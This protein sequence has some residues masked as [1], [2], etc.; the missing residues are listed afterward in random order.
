MTPS[1]NVNSQVNER[2]REERNVT[3]YSNILIHHHNHLTSPPLCISDSLLSGK[4]AEKDIE[5]HFAKCI[6]ALAERKAVLLGEAAL[7]VT[8]QS[9]IHSSYTLLSGSLYPFNHSLSS[10]SSH[11]HIVKVI[12]DT[13]VKLEVSIKACRKTL[14]AGSVTYAVSPSTAEIIWKVISSSLILAFL[15]RSPLLC[16]P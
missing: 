5:E 6:N 12:E 16:S 1:S 10:I 13:R 7:K 4:E 9:M 2:G 11:L 3:P 15:S 8:N 14:K